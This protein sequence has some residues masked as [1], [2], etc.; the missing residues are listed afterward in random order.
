MS[1]ELHTLERIINAAYSVEEFFLL[2][3][4]I[5]L[6]ELTELARTGAELLVLAD[7]A[8]SALLGCVC[9]NVAAE[10]GRVSLLSVDQAH[11]GRGYSRI[12]LDAAQSLLASSACKRVQVEVVNLRRELIPYYQRFGFTAVGVQ[13]FPKP[14]KLKRA[15]H[16]IV[17]QKALIPTPV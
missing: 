5:D 1:A 13:P 10:T 3:G 12:L 2:G 16:L 9:V 4:R 14:W 6:S 8:A 7:D 17:M 11:Q 15:A